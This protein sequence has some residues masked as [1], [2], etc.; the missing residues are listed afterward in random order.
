LI[1]NGRLLHMKIKVITVDLEIPRRTKRM[2]LLI[3]LPVLLLG[4][5]AVAVAGVVNT[6]HD[7]DVLHAKELNDNFVDLDARIA[8]LAAK[9]SDYSANA[10]FCGG[11]AN[12]PGNLGGYSGAKTTCGGTCKLAGQSSPT[13]HMCTGEEL[14]H[15]LAVGKNPPTGWYA[16]GVGS[17]CFGYTSTEVQRN[18]S[19]WAGGGPTY[20]SCEQI[21]PVLCCD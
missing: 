4:L 3:G 12:L 6:F 11:S 14:V 19:L 16:S 9:Q 10:T 17:D 15:S 13:A 7:G 18:G 20:D 5:S 21:A 2:A 1:E 8:N